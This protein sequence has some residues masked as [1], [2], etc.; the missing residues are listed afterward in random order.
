MSKLITFAL[1]RALMELAKNISQNAS[2]IPPKAAAP[3]R[4]EFVQICLARLERRMAQCTKIK[5]LIPDKYDDRTVALR[6]MCRYIT[7]AER[8]VFNVARGDFPGKY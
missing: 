2:S 6:N 7:K 3:C 8:I 1:P 5:P 4:N